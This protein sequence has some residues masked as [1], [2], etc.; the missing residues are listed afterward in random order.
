MQVVSMTSPTVFARAI[1]KLIVVT[2]AI[3]ILA[4]PDSAK[5]SANLKK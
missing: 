5:F 1:V 4:V 2:L 3:A